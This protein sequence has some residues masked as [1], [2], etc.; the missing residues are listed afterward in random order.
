MYEC[1]HE[2]VCSVTQSC[3]TL[4]D[5]MNP[6]LLN[7]QASLLL[8]HQVQYCVHAKSLQ[9]CPTLCNPMGCSSPGSSVHGFLQA[10]ILEW[11]AMP[12]QGS[13]LH[14]LRQPALAGRFF[15]T[16]ATWET[17]EHSG[18]ILNP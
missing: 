4:F 17:Q 8:S 14:L 16:I 11:V 13:N 10:R 2:H 7:W 1:V 6:H 9:L 5:L 3:L 12:T 15:T 18:V